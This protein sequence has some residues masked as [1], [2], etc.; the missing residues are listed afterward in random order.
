MPQPLGYRWAIRMGIRLQRRSKTKSRKRLR[1]PR[2]GDQGERTEG[3]ALVFVTP[4]NW[5]G[6][7]TWRQEKEALGKWKS[8]RVYDASDIEQWLEQSLQAQ[9]WISEIIGAPSDGVYSLE[10]RWHAWASVTDPELSKEIFAPSVEHFK[11][12]VTDWI[13]N[14]S[15]RPSSS[16]VIRRSRS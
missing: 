5:K 2:K 12:T 1:G 8:V 14:P 6:K 11:K 7:D 9:R 13:Q 3:D 15:L 16:V 10:E 4:R